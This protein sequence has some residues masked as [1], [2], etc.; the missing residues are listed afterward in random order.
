MVKRQHEDT[1]RNQASIEPTQ[2]VLLSE[3]H[4]RL[5]KQI[6]QIDLAWRDSIER[7]KQSESEVANRLSGQNN[8][9]TAT[10]ICR[11]WFSSSAAALLAE[12]Q[13]A[14]NLW[15]NF[16][17]GSLGSGWVR[18]SLAHASVHIAHPPVE[19]SAATHR[20]T[21]LTD[22]GATRSSKMADRRSGDARGA[23]R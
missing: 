14:T 21:L 3:A 9:E 12:S 20:E 7:L 13:R 18:A 8:Q 10:E 5:F 4:F 15:L 17:T 22:S 2:N 11:Q 1:V 6:E 19:P 23:R 16:Y